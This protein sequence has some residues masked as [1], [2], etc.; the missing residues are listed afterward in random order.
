[1][2][3]FVFALT[4]TKNLQTAAAPPSSWAKRLNEMNTERNDFPTSGPRFGPGDRWREHSSPPGAGRLDLIQ[5]SNS[6]GDGSSV[7]EVVGKKDKQ[8]LIT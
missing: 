1:M 6:E 8:Q 5:P 2:R 4:K 3:V 7:R